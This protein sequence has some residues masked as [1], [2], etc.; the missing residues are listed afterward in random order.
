MNWVQN[1][2]FTYSNLN[3]YKKDIIINQ[4]KLFIKRIEFYFWSQLYF[5]N[6]IV[7]GIRS[8][9]ITTEVKPIRNYQKENKKKHKF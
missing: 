6:I 5:Y 7:Q 2:G 9:I 1:G 3:S 4:H 8:I